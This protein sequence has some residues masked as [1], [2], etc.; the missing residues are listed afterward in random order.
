MF[1]DTCWYGY[2]FLDL[3]RGNRAKSFSSLFS[4]TLYKD[5]SN[6][7]LLGILLDERVKAVKIFRYASYWSTSQW[8]LSAKNC[9]RTFS[10]YKLY[11]HSVVG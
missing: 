3:V 4:Y 10:T 8:T 9:I 5:C 11:I 7:T 1:P 2:F 6:V